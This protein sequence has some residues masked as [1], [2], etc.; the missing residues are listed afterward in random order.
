MTGGPGTSRAQMITRH[1]RPLQPV[2]SMSVR[3]D[4][5]R[6]PA[7][8]APPKIRVSVLSLDRLDEFGLL[9]LIGSR[10]ELTPVAPGSGDEVDVRVVVAARLNA[11]MIR[12]L[13]TTG[14]DAGP[15]IVMILSEIGD[16]DL[17]AAVE[18]GL[19]GVIW[20][21]EL[22]ADRLAR[23][24]VR[25]NDGSSFLP[26]DFQ[27]RLLQAVVEVQRNV[28]SP[29]EL[30]A[31]GLSER[32]IGVLRLIAE[33]LGTGQVAQQL[34]YSERTVRAVLHGI[35]TRLGLRNRSHAVAYAMRAGVL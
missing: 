30:N 7:E 12:R 25:V 10:A 18:A 24:L 28:L 5:E 21:H 3:T 34:K 29:R 15:P 6:A 14:R 31:C 4:L 19:R 9:T 17:L 32:E 1:S 13:W 22:T 27:T 16:V 11:Q 35:T 23:V 20:R 26:V 2:R 33:G 8:I